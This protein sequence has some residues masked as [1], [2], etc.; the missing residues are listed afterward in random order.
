MSQLE[1]SGDYTHELLHEDI[2]ESPASR[3]DYLQTFGTKNDTNDSGQW[4][5]GHVQSIPDEG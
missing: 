1:L 3:I 5:F 2:V 4:G